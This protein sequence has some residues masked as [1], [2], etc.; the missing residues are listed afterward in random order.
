MFPLLSSLLPQE[1]LQMLLLL[2]VLLRFSHDLCFIDYFFEPFHLALVNLGEDGIP[3]GNFPLCLFSFEVTK[4]VGRFLVRE[5]AFHLFVLQNCVHLFLDLDLPH[6]RILGNKSLALSSFRLLFHNLYLDNSLL[7]LDNFVYGTG[8]LLFSCPLFVGT[9]SQA[10]P[11]PRAY[12]GYLSKCVSPWAC[13]HVFISFQKS[14]LE[15]YQWH[16]LIIRIRTIELYLF[17]SYLIYQC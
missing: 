9:L 6:R 4:Q 1:V 3:G 17:W 13:L 5:N 10:R 12:S 15:G 11:K 7:H 8:R 14:V 2:Q 16:P